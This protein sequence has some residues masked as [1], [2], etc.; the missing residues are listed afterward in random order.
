MAVM[1]LLKTLYF[2]I[3]KPENSIEYYF[4]TDIELWMSIYLKK[5]SIRDFRIP[6]FVQLM[7]TELAW[8]HVRILQYKKI[9]RGLKE[10][11]EGKNYCCYVGTS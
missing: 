11:K 3:F 4:F 6:R 2:Q 10:K 1:K 5:K 7:K 9:H 8:C